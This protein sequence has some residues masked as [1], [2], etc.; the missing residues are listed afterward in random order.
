MIH[1]VS[2]FLKHLSI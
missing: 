1:G 2:S